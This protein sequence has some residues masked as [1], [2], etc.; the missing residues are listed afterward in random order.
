[1][2]Q[3][4]E[5]FFIDLLTQVI[6]INVNDIG[7]TVEGIIPDVVPLSWHVKARIRVAHQVFEQPY[8]LAVRSISVLRATPVWLY[9][10]KAQISKCD[11]GTTI[12]SSRRNRARTR[13]VKLGKGKRLGEV[14]VGSP[15]SRPETISS[16]VVLAVSISRSTLP[17]LP[18]LLDHRQ[19][20]FFGKHSN[21]G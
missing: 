6:D 12:L 11:L 3:F 4:G 2:D 13:A 5:K 14:I 19:A 10:V 7:K 9:R 21:P 16:V 17:G 20:I 18:Q 15:A 8:S 1:M